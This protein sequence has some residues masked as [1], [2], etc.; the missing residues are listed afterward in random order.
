MKTVKE[1]Q[2]AVLAKVHQTGTEIVELRD[3]FGRIFAGNATSNRN[4]PPTDISAMDGYAVRF[5]DISGASKDAPAS[6]KIVDDIRAGKDPECEVAS[7]EAARI[8]TGAPIP[9]GI[10][11]VV[12][13][14]D[15]DCNDTHVKIFTPSPEGSN[16]RLKAENLKIGDTV[17]NKG[18]KLGSAEIGILAMIKQQVVEVRKK[19]R[20]AILSSGDEIEAL[21]APFDPKKIPDANSYSVMAELLSIGIEPTLLGVAGDTEGEL[22]AKLE[23]GLKYDALI[24]SGGVSVGHHDFVRPTLKSLGVEMHFWRVALRPGH[25]FAF[26]TTKDTLVFALPGNPVSSMVC[27][28]LF[29]VPALRASVGHENIFRR[30]VKA[31]LKGSAK[32][33][34]GRMHFMRVKLSEENDNL[35]AELTGSQGSG[36]LRSMVEADGLIAVPEDLALIEDGQEVTV[37]LFD[38]HGFQKTSGLPE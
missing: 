24:V 32:D 25:P 9:I 29:V 10:D 7:G 12:R 18:A 3:A 33:K 13:V 11:T 1:A 26:G 34:K 23:E 4:H 14:E 31:K 5:S 19:P 28:T 20:V 27:T 8:M 17:L 36:I 22:K 2:A 15:T 21:G 6:L 30:T 37:L 16:I 38:G 35:I